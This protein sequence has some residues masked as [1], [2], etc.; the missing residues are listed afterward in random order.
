MH[1]PPACA[2]RL[3]ASSTLLL[4]SGILVAARDPLNGSGGILAAFD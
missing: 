3:E 2:T 4:L 1:E